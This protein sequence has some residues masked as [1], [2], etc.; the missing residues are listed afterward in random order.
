MSLKEGLQDVLEENIYGGQDWDKI[1]NAV[2]IYFHKNGMVIQ[3]DKVNP[4]FQYG[5]TVPLM[6]DI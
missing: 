4:D 5:K 6:E 3:L 1:V 2:F